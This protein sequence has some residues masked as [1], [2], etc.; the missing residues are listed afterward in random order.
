MSIRINTYYLAMVLLLS[1]AMGI[2]IV[3]VPWLATEY[4]ALSPFFIAL[5]QSAVLIP[6]IAL[7]VF[8]GVSLDKGE[9]FNKFQGLLLASS[10]IHLLFLL[11]LTQQGLSLLWVLLYAF[12]LGAINA[13]VQPYKEYL[14]GLLATSDLQAHIA[15]NR[16]CLYLG[17]GIGIGLASQLYPSFL[18]LLPM[19]QVFALF[20]VFMC[21]VL[22]KRQKGRGV[23]TIDINQNK[24]KF[25]YSLLTSGFKFCWGSKTLRSLLTITAINGFFHM[26][27][28]I[29]ALPILV[30]TIYGGDVELFSFLQGLFTAGMFLSAL[31]IIY[32]KKLDGPGRR[33]I[34]SILYSGLILLGLSAGPTVTGLLF[35]VFLWGVV[36]GI[37]ATLGRSILQSS[38]DPEYM[39]RV[40]SIYQL[41]LFGFAP[42]GALCA[43]IA[44][45]SLGV[46]M[47]LKLSAIM[48]FIAFAGTFFIRSLWDVEATDA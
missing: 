5:V 44:I 39:G 32:R 28:F 36:V 21:L 20:L 11:L 27:V 41:T 40:I 37:S 15:K 35:L 48:S 47:V 6:N 13:F 29:V 1:L 43:G 2:Q 14:A 25:S 3:V 30:K 10:V 17:Q 24:E 16:I 42:L 9:L 26:G 33:M 12:L 7:L 8:G 38:T 31:I 46:L 23:V 19:I 34:F 22:I 45:S 18:I 4:L